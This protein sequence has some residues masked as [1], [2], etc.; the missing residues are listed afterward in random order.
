MQV[1]FFYLALLYEEGKGVEKSLSRAYELFNKA[2]ELGDE[3]ARSHIGRM[4]YFGLGVLRDRVQA[5]TIW[6]E[7]AKSGGEYE[8]ERAMKFY[9]MGECD[10]I[11]KK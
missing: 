11:L 4:L 7:I 10:M 6:L 8:K 5:C 3:S 9:N 2:A 1:L